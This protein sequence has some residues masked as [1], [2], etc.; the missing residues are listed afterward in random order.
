MV[1]IPQQAHLSGH[2]PGHHGHGRIALSADEVP[3]ELHTGHVERAAAGVGI[4]HEL[5]RIG[6]VADELAQ[7]PQRLLGG[8]APVRVGLDGGASRGSPRGPSR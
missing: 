4:A 2:G 8:M 5:A 3:A 7:E 6:E 1:D